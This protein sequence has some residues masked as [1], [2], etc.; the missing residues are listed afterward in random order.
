MEVVLGSKYDPQ[1]ERCMEVY[2]EEN[3]KVQR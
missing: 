2:E 1:K 3:K